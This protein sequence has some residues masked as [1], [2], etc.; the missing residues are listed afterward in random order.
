MYNKFDNPSENL[1]LIP[2]IFYQT[3]DVV[4]MARKLLGKTVLTRT[5]QGICTAKIVE[6]EAY[7]G[8]DDRGC[9]AYG[10]RYTERTKTM[11]KQG[12]TAYVY[13]CYGIHP[14]LNVVTGPEGHAHAV[15]IRAVQPLDGIELMKIRR[16]TEVIESLTSGPGKLTVAMGIT[17]HMDGVSL[18]DTYSPVIILDNSDT[19]D[20]TNIV[21][22]PRVGMSK[23]VGSCSHR[24][25]RFYLKGNP[26]VSKP[27]KVDY[28]GKW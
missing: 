18:F 2:S 24:P 5:P 10:G 23:H 17:R 15:L 16:Q 28:T 1:A 19:I 4:S 3:D 25:W 27:L 9:H 12:G 14:M 6:T 22:G 26:F 13:M 11:Y 8:P 20:N 7:R 21:E